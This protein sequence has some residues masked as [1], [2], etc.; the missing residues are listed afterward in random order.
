M[1]I[2]IVPS[3]TVNTT[4]GSIGISVVSITPAESTATISVTFYD[5]YHKRLDRVYLELTGTDYS[6]WVEDAWLVTY[7][8]EHVNATAYAGDY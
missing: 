8:L 6:N 1:D 3:F 7:V 2:S 5:R 4:Q